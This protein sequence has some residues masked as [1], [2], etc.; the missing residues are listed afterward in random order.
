MRC[1]RLTGRPT[2]VRLVDGRICRGNRLGRAD[3]AAVGNLFRYN[4]GCEARRSAIP[5]HALWV[6]A[7]HGVGA[8]QAL[9]TSKDLFE[10]TPVLQNWEG[11]DTG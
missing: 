6:L 3:E 1:A 4:T 9:F 10:G 2:T 8:S 5:G 7:Y 11:R